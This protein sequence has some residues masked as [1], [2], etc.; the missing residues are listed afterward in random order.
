MLSSSLRLLLTRPGCLWPDMG[1]S[2]DGLGRGEGEMTTDGG[3]CTQRHF[4]ETA[5]WYLLNFPK[6]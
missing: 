6:Y 3:D 2:E 1:S 4:L 5:N